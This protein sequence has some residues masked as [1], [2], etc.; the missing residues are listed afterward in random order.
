[1][2]YILHTLRPHSFLVVHSVIFWLLLSMT[3]PFEVVDVVF[4]GVPFVLGVNDIPSP[5]HLCAVTHSIIDGGESQSVHILR[6][7]SKCIKV[8]TRPTHQGTLESS[9]GRK[10]NLPI[11]ANG[12]VSWVVMAMFHLRHGDASNSIFVIFSIP[13]CRKLSRSACFLIN[14]L[15]LVDTNLVSIGFVV[16][17]IDRRLNTSTLNSTI[18]QKRSIRRAS[19]SSSIDV[20]L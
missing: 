8:S 4:F 16:K 7:G 1:M 19:R 13:R 3:L 17:F 5:A 12:L 20:S 2:I 11:V 14:F 10:F 15:T 6:R 18:L 9:L